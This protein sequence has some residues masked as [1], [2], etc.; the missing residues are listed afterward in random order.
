ML[1][2]A[3][4]SSKDIIY[5]PGFNAGITRAKQIVTIHDLIHLRQPGG[6]SK[7]KRVF[8]DRVLKPAVMRSG[9]VFT[10][11]EDSKRDI[12]AWLGNDDVDIVNAGCG[13]SDSF[14]VEG[15]VEPLGPAEFIYVGNLK[16]HKNAEVL[17]D[18]LKIRPGYRILWITASG[19]ELRKM[20]A[21]R[22]VES[23]VQVKFG[24][25]DS[26]LAA[27][28][29]GSSGLLFPSTLEGFGLP[30]V[31][32]LSTGTPVAF[33]EVCAVVA[34]NVGLGG[35]SVQDAYSSYEWAQAMD[36]LLAYQKGALEGIAETL[37]RNFDW[38][39]V[40]D[41]VTTSL[42]RIL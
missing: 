29:R 15:P 12:R 41:R 27:H 25:S 42:R 7:P 33:S 21:I 23:Q 26:E 39:G 24:L 5:S 19:N 4:L 40:A 35:V 20:A 38:S 34:E 31:E 14:V 30:P 28:Y 16:T 11:S 17:L 1:A 32:A 10:D 8:Y 13:I 18:A 36:Q 37:R 6:L 2:G 9:L 22:K 3:S